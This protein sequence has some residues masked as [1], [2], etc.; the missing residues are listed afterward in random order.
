[1]APS[2]E[3]GQPKAPDKIDGKVAS[4]VPVDKSAD[5]GIQPKPSSSAISS[6]STAVPSSSA[7]TMVA[8]QQDTEVKHKKNDMKN[9]LSRNLCV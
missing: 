4:V 3:L 6:S 9:V 8:T 7:T 2:P 1:M 5:F